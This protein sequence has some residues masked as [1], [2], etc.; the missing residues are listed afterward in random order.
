MIATERAGG[1]GPMGRAM[2]SSDDAEP[3][4]KAAVNYRGAASPTLKGL[5]PR[6]YHKESAT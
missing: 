2:V 1:P 4:P 6:A 5:R 3:E